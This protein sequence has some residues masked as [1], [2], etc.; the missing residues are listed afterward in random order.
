MNTK[1]PLALAAAALVLLATT[2]CNRNE[3][4]SGG[5]NNTPAATADTAADDATTAGTTAAGT[6]TAPAPTDAAAGAPPSQTEALALLN[7]VNQHEVRTAE[8]AKSKN[9]TG[10]VLAYANMMHAEHTKN[11]ADTSALLTKAGGAPADSPAL[12]AQKSKGDAAAQQLDALTGDAYAKAYIDAMVM[13]HQD[14][15]TKLDSMLIP[16]ATDPAVRQHL[17]MTRGHVQQHLDRA[18]EIQGK[19]G[20]APAAA[21]G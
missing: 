6:P 17:E 14:A 16:A 10:D 12:S 1:T 21:N 7:V 9:V 5:T 4:A 13:D 8:Q 2:A 3:D 15:L 19:L 11:M 20:A 18:K